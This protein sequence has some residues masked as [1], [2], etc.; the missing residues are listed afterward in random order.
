MASRVA[1]RNAYSARVGGAGD[2]GD[3]EGQNARG[4]RARRTRHPARTRRGSRKTRHRASRAF[5]RATLCRISFPNASRT[6][7][8]R[9]SRTKPRRPRRPTPTRVPR[10]EANAR[11]H[12]GSTSPGATAR[13]EASRVRLFSTRLSRFVSPRTRAR[14]P[15]TP[16]TRRRRSPADAHAAAAHSATAT[17]PAS[18][19]ETLARSTSAVSAVSV[20]VSSKRSAGDLRV[21]A[22][23]DPRGDRRAESGEE[24]A[25]RVP[26]RTRRVADAFPGTR[27][28]RRRSGPRKLPPKSADA[29]APLTSASAAGRTPTAPLAPTRSDSRGEAPP[30]PGTAPPPQPPARRR[31]AG[32]GVGHDSATSASERYSDV[33]NDARRAHRA[34]PARRAA[35]RGRLGAGRASGAPRRAARMPRRRARWLWETRR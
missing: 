5:A 9:A 20:C 16:R 35:W 4:I 2:A 10:R 12:R 30:R 34:P 23:R 29:E 25:E 33:S 32:G 17:A 15:A 3:D 28:S 14:A 7:R 11:A 6:R 8:A 21:A 31:R 1:T 19:L 22:L 26:K 27:A 18:K 24:R 13:F